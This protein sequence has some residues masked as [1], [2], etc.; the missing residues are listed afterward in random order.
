[1]IVITDLLKKPFDEGAKNTA[2]NIVCSIGANEENKI[3]SING[4]KGVGEGVDVSNVNK[5]FI[6]IAFLKKIRN[7]RCKTVLY[8]PE[9][10]STL[11]S[12]LRSKIIEVFTKKSICILAL[13]PRRY[14]GLKRVLF[15]ALS[16]SMILTPSESYAEYLGEQGV[17]SIPIPLGVD[18][19]R[20]NPYTK[21]GRDI[22]RCD[23][24]IA[25]DRFVVLHVGHIS[26]SRN[27]SWMMDI[28]E[29]FPDIEV[30]VVG[31]TYNQSDS[32]LREK[33]V[34]LGVV[35]ID[36]YIEDMADIYN[37]ADVYVFPVLNDQGAIATPLSVLEAMAC[38]LPIV[39]SKF[40]SLPDV[41]C[42]SPD[43]NYVDDS[44]DL[45]KAIGVQRNGAVASNNRKK[46]E[47][48]TWKNIAHSIE[49]LLEA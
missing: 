33:L 7:L 48:Y 34:D 16:P 25:I 44:R 19:S 18:D 40:G 41:F 24:N 12:L 49:K 15:S 8:I 28:K 11:F 13:Q 47:K 5:T 9:S 30:V 6:D 2:L 38:N 45:I 26:V 3:F 17:S 4:S 29:T 39:T 37:I 14:I 35:I 46:I 36:Q 21:E 22:A 1:M 43:F 32:E 20:Y 23:Y 27:L 10:S 42:E 31:S